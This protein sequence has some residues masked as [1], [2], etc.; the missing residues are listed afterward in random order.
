MKRLTTLAF[1]FTLI[2]GSA[3]HIQAQVVLVAP[4]WQP[5]PMPVR[6]VPVVPFSPPATQIER[7]YYLPSTPAPPVHS[8]DEPTDDAGTAKSPEPSQ[9]RLPDAEPEII[10]REYYLPSDADRDRWIDTRPRPGLHRDRLVAP[11]WTPEY[12]RTE[13]LED[14]ADSVAAP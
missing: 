9:D 1:T 14:A 11:P 6:L 12:E 7:Y 3:D 2:L 13:P 10:I 5:L 8:T 4:Q